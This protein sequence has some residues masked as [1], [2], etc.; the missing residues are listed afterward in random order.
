MRVPPFADLVAFDA[1][2][3]KQTLSRAAQELN[4][5]Q[6]AISRRIAQL[7]NNLGCKLFS[8]TS[9]PLKLTP[10]GHKLFEALRSGL[11]RIEA[12]VAEIRDSGVEKTI[13][14]RMSSGFAL[15][16]LTPRLR[17]LQAAFPDTHFRILSGEESQE[18]TDG[19]L[20][21]R[22]GSGIWPHM[23]AA[24]IFGE[25][26]FAVC[27]PLYLAGRKPLLSIAEIQR[28]KLLSIGETERRWHTWASWFEALGHPMPRK[29]GGL[30]FDSFILMINAT[31]AGQGIGLCWSGLLDTFLASGA[32]VRV[33]K[34]AVRSDRGYYV[35]YHRGSGT[36]STTQM[37]ANWLTQAHEVRT[38]MQEAPFR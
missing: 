18:M 6:P 31:L 3:R 8:R 27:S 16:W 25:E 1:A 19:D 24:R 37:V 4:V 11:S 12:A 9:K 38:I 22:F 29:P 23:I 32:L 10:Q 33:S 28:E 35:T 14:I 36:K 26:V 13:T 2:V 20:Q 17:A 21:V 34:E 7:E 5:T 30:D 15:F